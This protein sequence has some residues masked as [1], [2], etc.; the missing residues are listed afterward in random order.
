MFGLN[1]IYLKIGFALAAIGAVILLASPLLA[2]VT[3]SVSRLGQ[4]AGLAL[5]AGTVL[6][7]MGRIVQVR[8]RRSQT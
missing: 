6:Y 8:A 3:M 2:G 1:N 7:L 4:I 5:I